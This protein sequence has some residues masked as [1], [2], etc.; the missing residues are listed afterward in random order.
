MPSDVKERAVPDEETE[1]IKNIKDTQVKQW[2]PYPVVMASSLPCIH[3]LVSLLF[4]SKAN[5]T[6][7]MWGMGLNLR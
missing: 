3:Y 1:A 7:S 4:T 2:Y 5:F 6:Y